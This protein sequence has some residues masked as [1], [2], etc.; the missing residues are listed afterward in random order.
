MHLILSLY[1]MVT[2]YNC[3]LNSVNLMKILS[4][5]ALK[6]FIQLMDKVFINSLTMIKNNIF[7]LILNLIQLIKCKEFLI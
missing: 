6:I 4:S 3:Q 2:F 5:L 7:I 1:G